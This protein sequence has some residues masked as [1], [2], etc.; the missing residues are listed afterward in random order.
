MTDPIIEHVY[1]C[2]NCPF[3]RTE[4]IEGTEFYP[5]TR[6]W[7][8]DMLSSARL[9]AQTGYPPH[10]YRDVACPLNERDVIIRVAP[11]RA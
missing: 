8:C 2:R 10:E 6:R 7:W 3:C 1:A 5:T 9:P 4:V 11:E